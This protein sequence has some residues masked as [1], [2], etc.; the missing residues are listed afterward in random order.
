MPATVASVTAA[1]RHAAATTPDA[2][3][4]TRR[5]GRPAPAHPQGLVSLRLCTG[6]GALADTVVSR[7]EGDAYRAA[8]DVRLGEERPSSHVVGRGVHPG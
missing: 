7:R 8:R 5:Q 3:A 2:A 1:L 6:T 4:P